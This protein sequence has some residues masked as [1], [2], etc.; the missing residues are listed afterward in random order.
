MPCSLFWR[1]ASQELW[2]RGSTATA[3]TFLS[4]LWSTYNL[5]LLYYM[6]SIVNASTST[7]PDKY[8][9]KNIPMKSLRTWNVARVRLGC[10]TRRVWSH[11]VLVDLS[12]TPAN[13]CKDDSTLHLALDA[14]ETTHTPY[15]W[16]M[17][18]RSSHATNVKLKLWP[19]EAPS[20]KFK[21]KS[22]P[23]LIYPSSFVQIFDLSESVWVTIVWVHMEEG[24]PEKA[25][26]CI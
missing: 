17:L 23:N 9:K 26:E 24:D 11:Q 1:S 2:P 7:C 21:F 20:S 5:L 6:L 12:P 19:F 15:R 8:M 13:D 10:P 22:H 4:I 3:N 25:F 16:S 14:L 18:S